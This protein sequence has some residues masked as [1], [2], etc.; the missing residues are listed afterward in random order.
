MAAQKVVRTGLTFDDV[1]LVP[2]HSAVLPS[3]VDTATRFTRRLNLNIPI[4]SAGM[5]T[6]TESRMAIAMAREGGIGVIHKNLTIEQQAV[7]VDKVKRS[8]HGVIWHPIFL[9]RDHTIRDAL[10]M[11][12]K[13]R[14]S[15]VPIIEGERLVGIIT[16][17]DL[18]FEEDLDRPLQ[19]AMTS[20]G[21]VTAP[22]GTTL[23]EAKA[24]MAKY[25]I[26]KLPLV[27]EEYHLRGLITIKDIE[28]AQKFPNSAKDAKGRLLV[29]AAIGVSKENKERAKALV[30]AGVDCLVLDTAHGHSKN[31]LD[32][33]EMIK[34]LF[35]KVQLVAGNVAT[36]A[37]TKALIKAGADAVKAGVGPG[38]I[39]VDGETEILMGNGGV[40]PIS[41]VMPGDH[42]VTH[43][44]NVREVHRVYR[45]RYVGPVLNIDING[46]PRTLRITPNHPFYA[47]HFDAPLA[48]R[49]HFGGRYFFDKPKHNH[50]VDWVEAGSLMPKDV[51][52]MPHRLVRPLEVEYDLRFYVPNDQSEDEWL[53][54]RK[55]SANPNVETYAKSAERYGTTARVV[56]DIVRQE[57]RLQDALQV[58]VAE[59]LDSVDYIP[60]RPLHHVRR[61]VRLD[62]RLMRLLGYYAAE[63]HCA[64]AHESRQLR[65]TFHEDEKEYHEDVARLIG[66]VFDYHGTS[67]VHSQRGKGVTVV[68]SS[69]ALATF[70][71][72]LI[73]GHASEK[74]VPREV[75]DQTP[76]LLREF[77][78][79]AIRG[80]GTLHERGRVSYKTT[81]PSLA[82]QVADV[83]M[84]LGYTPSVQRT[85]AKRSNWHATYTVRI[86]GAQVGRFLE[87]FPE[88]AHKVGE[89]PRALR[90]QGMWHGKDGT[91]TTIRD[92]RVTREELFVYNLEVE[93]DESYVANRVAVHNCTTRVVAGIGVPQ[94]TAIL[95]CVEAAAAE[96]VPVIAD[97]GIRA[98]GDITKALAAGAHSV[99]LGSMLA[100]TDESPGEMEIFMGRSFKVYR[101]MGSLGAMRAG[102][103]DR[104]FQEGQRKLVPEGIEG[105]VPYRGPLSETIFQAIG[106]L[107][108]GMGYLGVDSV[109]Q[110]RTVTEFI[111]ITNAGLRESHP[112][113]VDITKEP[114]NYQR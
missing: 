111:Q 53:I 27:D 57:R 95:D 2:A 96:D 3:D 64:G 105:R 25:R 101:G 68:V 109:E 102:S 65:F 42:V 46:S 91:Y 24:V 103:S 54:A 114:P 79:G 36:A 31:V 72:T 73:P 69:H 21:L 59:Y 50:G 85:E 108:A 70:F 30:D 61:K 58:A 98:S 71:S 74:R 93:E 66:D 90:Q 86:S 55:P 10:E 81:S 20:E 26:E 14:I 8:E 49:R 33:V 60:P 15:G 113:D 78:I 16:N 9:T 67:M 56:G 97:G 39:C 84:R 6:V 92:I 23:A 43:L 40:K 75:L 99:M 13:Y 89:P 1:L 87:E 104:Y 94:V 106:G 38:S 82:S 63:G 110:L 48:Q 41:Q 83:L 12:A 34:G 29:A 35:P 100:G 32:A 112:H 17:R 11:M 28:K 80:D 47:M 19:Q 52:V 88:L 77:L 37:G 4:V 22:V 44:G 76:E 107:R 62:G 18:R 51:L 7:E 5:D 45:R